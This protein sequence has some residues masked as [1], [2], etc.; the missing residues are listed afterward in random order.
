MLA[1]LNFNRQIWPGA[2]RR[3]SRNFTGMKAHFRVSIL[4]HEGR[5]MIQKSHTRTLQ[6]HSLQYSLSGSVVGLLDPQAHRRA[7]WPTTHRGSLETQLERPSCQPVGAASAAIHENL[8]WFVA[9]TCGSQSHPQLPTEL[10]E[11]A[12]SHRRGPQAGRYTTRKWW[13]AIAEQ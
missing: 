9:A 8:L 3:P 2:S 11:I 7:G 4:K 12:H 1:S 13:G 6:N 5:C 10:W